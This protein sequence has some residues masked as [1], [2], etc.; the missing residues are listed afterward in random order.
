M[1]IGSYV[2]SARSDSIQIL[3]LVP[4][5]LSTCTNLLA[6][7]RR[8]AFINVRNEYNVLIKN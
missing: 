5:T 4:L 3:F 1:Y 2:E 7:R 8:I 6:T